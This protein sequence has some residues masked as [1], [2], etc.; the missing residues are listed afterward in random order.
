MQGRI[1]LF[2][3]IFAVLFAALGLLACVYAFLFGSIYNQPPQGDPKE[4]VQLFFDGVRVGNYRIA[5]SCLSD[6]F[7]LGLENEPES[8]EARQLYRALKGSYSYNLLGESTVDGIHATQR[9]S[10]RALNIRR[11]E[12]AVA[13]RVD[14]VLEETVKDLPESSVY[15]EDGKYLQSL[16]D[17]VYSRALEQVLGDQGSMES[18]KQDTVLEI[19]LVYRDGLWKIVTDRALMSAL[20]GGEN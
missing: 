14:A 18:L 3:L 17:T 10:L 11:T 7:S 20:M 5:Y 15:D 16:T 1:R 8:E 13:Q 2:W 12:D 6:Y 19:H 4:T 9:V